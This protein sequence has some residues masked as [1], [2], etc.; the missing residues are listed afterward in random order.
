[1]SIQSVS[2]RAGYD[3]WAA[4][5]DAD[6]NPLPA[7]E[8]PLTE[9]LIG[10]VRGFTVLDLGCGTG[11]HAVLLAAAGAT[12]EALDFS[13]PMLDRARGKAGTS[14]INFR[15][16][17]L[18]QPLPFPAATFDLVLC[19]LVLEHIATLDSFF[20]EMHRVCRPAGKVIISVM[21]PAMLLL[22]VQARFRDP[23]SGAETRLA[24]CAHQVSDYV[25]AATRAGFAIDHM[26]EHAPD[27]ALASRVERARRY[28][29]W[30]MLLLMRLLPE[31]DESQC[32]R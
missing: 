15:M 4:N 16:H 13:P 22:G 32:A 8:A 10:D 6:C 14:A 7:L 21:H 27:E 23:D 20:R 31:K 9:A 12:V 11:R 25:V 30:P 18:T 19:A 26:S 1:M 3:S 24:T 17:D 5:Y 2:T 28:L 29:N